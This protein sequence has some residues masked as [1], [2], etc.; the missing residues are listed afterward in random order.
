MQ[1][2][3][4]MK[5]NIYKAED[6]RTTD[7]EQTLNF[8]MNIIKVENS[9]SEILNNIHLFRELKW[10]IRKLIVFVYSNFEKDLIFRGQLL[11]HTEIHNYRV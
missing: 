2:I 11:F 7:T 5:R 1:T 8:R 4:Y 6:D 9:Q 3:R 10:E